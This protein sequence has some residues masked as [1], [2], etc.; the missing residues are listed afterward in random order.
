MGKIGVIL[1]DYRFETF[2][3]WRK[4]TSCKCRCTL[5]C[6]DHT[7][8]FFTEVRLFVSTTDNERMIFSWKYVIN[9]SSQ[10]ILYYMSLKKAY[11]IPE[12]EGSLL[13]FYTYMSNL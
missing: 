13:Y 12:A 10:R 11:K 8:Y 6:E 3:S 7:T 2:I 5:H 4:T 1:N 9:L